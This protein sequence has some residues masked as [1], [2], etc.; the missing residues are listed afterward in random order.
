MDWIYGVATWRNI[1]PETDFFSV[2][3]R[4][5]SNGYEIRPGPDGNPV[6]WRKSIVQKF[7][8]RGDRFDPT[9]REFALDGEPQWVYLPDPAAEVEDAAA[10]SGS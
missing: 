2:T 1:D 5:F 3:L 10:A 7:T 6:V 9:Q 4:G 8:R